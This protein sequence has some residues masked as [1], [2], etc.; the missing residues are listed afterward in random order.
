MG[1]PV[2]VHLSGW[3]TVVETPQRA[4]KPWELWCVVPLGIF[5][6]KP[7]PPHWWVTWWLDSSFPSSLS[8]VIFLQTSSPVSHGACCLSSMGLLPPLCCTDSSCSASKILL[9]ISLLQDALPQ[10]PHGPLLSVCSPKILL[11]FCL[12]SSKEHVSTCLLSPSLSNPTYINCIMKHAFADW[13]L[14]WPT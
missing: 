5:S 6:D 12:Y 7:V 4:L 9:Q 14:Q 11:D 8:S 3:G 13:S 1:W 10:V 2:C